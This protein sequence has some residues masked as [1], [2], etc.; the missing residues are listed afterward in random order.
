MTKRN[1]LL[2]LTFTLGLASATAQPAWAQSYPNR[3]VKIIAAIPP[4]SANDVIARVIAQKLSEQN[5]AQF[6]VENLPGAGGTTGTGAAARAPADGYTLLIMNQDFV[7]QPLV[8][9]KVPYDP[10]KSFD[11]ISLAAVAPEVIVVHPSFPAKIMGELI[12]ILKANPGRY[13]YASPGHGTSPH[14]ASERLFRISNGLD[15]VHVPFQGGAP[16]VTSTVAGHTPILHITLPLVEAHIKSGALRALAIASNKRSPLFPDIPALS[17]AGYPGHEVSFWTGL[18]APQGTP[19]AVVSQLN[20]QIAEVLA[21]SDVRERLTAM[22]F[23]PMPTTPEVF[24]QHL[25][26]ETAV[27]SRV[28]RDGQLKID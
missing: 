1:G 20:R 7:I 25:A 11:P 15:V 22:G 3:P 8:K 19:T 5:G 28:V 6:I 13:S 4:G 27:W 18:V 2:L 26:T 24:G 23:A 21:M 12:Q 10:V 14:L 17:E 9:S 16:A